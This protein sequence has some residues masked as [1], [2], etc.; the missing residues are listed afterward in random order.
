[1]VEDYVLRMYAAQQPAGAGIDVEIVAVRSIP[2][3]PRRSLAIDFIHNLPIPVKQFLE[4]H[5]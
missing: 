5:S 2:Q 3:R 4:A 1:M